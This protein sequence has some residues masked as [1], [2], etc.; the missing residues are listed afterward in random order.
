VFSNR[1]H[2]K[3]LVQIIKNTFLFIYENQ[4]D[5]NLNYYMIY[6]RWRIRRTV[7]KY[8]EYYNRDAKYVAT[9]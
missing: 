3:L 8:N 6:F 1:N 9:R 5:Y 4:I 7:D 2:I